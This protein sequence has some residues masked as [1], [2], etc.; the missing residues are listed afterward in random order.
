MKNLEKNVKNLIMDIINSNDSNYERSKKF[1]LLFYNNQI[2][3]E[4]VQS[5]MKIM[6]YDVHPDLLNCSILEQKNIIKNYL[7][8][9]YHE[10]IITLD[11][12]LRL[13]YEHFR[14][15]GH[16]NESIFIQA[17]KAYLNNK[18]SYYT[19]FKLLEYSG[20][21]VNY[22]SLDYNEKDSKSY[23]AGYLLTYYHIRNIFIYDDELKKFIK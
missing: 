1:L 3:L 7:D 6:K 10:L 16:T 5:L 12:S 15:Q 2:D 17:S 21:Y 23:I 11:E 14:E 13:L 9:N 8:G 20:A 22:S 19:C 4:F 18:M